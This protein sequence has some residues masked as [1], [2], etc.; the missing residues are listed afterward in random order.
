MDIAN[1]TQAISWLKNSEVINLVDNKFVKTGLF[2]LLTSKFLPFAQTNETKK[3]FVFLESQMRYIRSAK[4]TYL[5]LSNALIKHCKNANQTSKKAAECF[6]RS[7]VKKGHK[8][9]YLN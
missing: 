8:S 2:G 5:E 4:K 1:Y 7:L 9:T 3:I 6:E